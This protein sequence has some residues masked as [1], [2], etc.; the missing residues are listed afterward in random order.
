VPILV[1]TEHTEFQQYHTAVVC[2][3][4]LASDFAY[5]SQEYIHLTVKD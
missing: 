2:V 4:A 5:V 3:S 1:H